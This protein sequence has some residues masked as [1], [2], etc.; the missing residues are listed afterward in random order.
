MQSRKIKTNFTWDLLNRYLINSFE[1]FYSICHFVVF[2]YLLSLIESFFESIKEN[3]WSPVG[4]LICS[5]DKSQMLQCKL[6]TRLSAPNKDLKISWSAQKDLCWQWYY[7][8]ALFCEKKNSLY[9]RSPFK[10][11]NK[12]L[13]FYERNLVT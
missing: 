2:S 8:S 12:G 4:V 7:K 10:N 13:N 11:T 3:I 5:S 9:R 1:S 6:V